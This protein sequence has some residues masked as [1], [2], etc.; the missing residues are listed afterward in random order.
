MINMYKPS[1]LSWKDDPQ[2]IGHLAVLS[3]LKEENFQPKVIYDIGS[4]EGNW[5]EMATTI[6]P[7]CEFYL[8]DANEDLNELYKERKYNYYLGLLSNTNDEQIKYYYNETFIAGNSYYKELT[9]AYSDDIYRIL[10]SA[11]LDKVIDNNAWPMPDLIKLD[12]QGSELDILE[13]GKKILSQAKYLIVELQ[14]I[15]YNDSAPLF[16]ESIA[17]IEKRGWKLINSKFSSSDYTIDADYLFK[18]L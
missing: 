5:T 14:H 9:E 10:N 3:K 8:F 12:V 1:G 16:E 7:N 13:G 11:T 4:C 18:K 15:E 17:T 2:Y 6:W